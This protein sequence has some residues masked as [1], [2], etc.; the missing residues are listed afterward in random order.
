[1]NEPRP[2][3]VPRAVRKAAVTLALP[4]VL[5]ASWAQAKAVPSP[6]P[7]APTETRTYTAA[8]SKVLGDNARR[9]AEE[10]QATWDRKMRAATGSI[11][12]GC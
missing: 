3:R 9:L 1:M 6:A 7:H 5:A 10:R 12:T 4:V 11:C 8:E 2:M